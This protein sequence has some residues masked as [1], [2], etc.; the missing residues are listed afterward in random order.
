MKKQA[1][2]IACGV[3]L[4]LCLPA[5]ASAAVSAQ[6]AAQLKSTLTPLGAEKAGSADNLVPTWTG[7]YAQ[8]SPG[9]KSGEVRPDPFASEKPIFSVTGGNMAKYS[10]MLTDGQ[11]GLLERYPDYRL[12]VYPSHRTASAPQAVYDATF[13]NATT[14]TET[15]NGNTLQNAFDG[16]P[17]PVVKT[18]IEAMWNH[19]VRWRGESVYFPFKAWVVDSDGRVTLASDA[20]N[21]WAWPFYYTGEEQTYGDLVQELY[22]VTD[23]PAFKSG[24]T[25]LVRDPLNLSD[26]QAWQ[27]LVGQR[28]VRRAPNLAYD[29]PSPV[30]SG[31]DFFDEPFGFTGALDRYTW[32]IIGKREM[33]VPYNDN[34]MFL[35]PTSSMTKVGHLSPDGVRW[36]VHRVWV[37]EAKLAPGQRHVMPHRVFYLDEDTWSVVLA[38]GWDAEGQLWHTEECFPSVYADFP[39]TIPVNF[40]T[41]DLLKNSYTY[42]TDGENHPQY[43]KVPHWPSQMFTPNY[44]ASKGVR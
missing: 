27:Y 30:N 38:D 10:A 33:I 15:D 4:G 42:T 39:G 25:I 9:Y 18:G 37:V 17:F 12:D 16:I 21:R 3:A 19:S 2:L 7:G 36:E 6:E 1:T 40:A 23:A 26:R 29:T 11:K 20:L 35:L 14:A 24:E 28:R 5:V 32:T 43:Q 44:V 34:G 8:T 41:F 31:V 13:R 22:Q